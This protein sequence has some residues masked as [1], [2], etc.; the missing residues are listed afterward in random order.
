[1]WEG[2]WRLCFVG[3]ESD[4]ELACYCFDVLRRQ[5]QRDIRRYQKLHCRRCKRGTR[6]QRTHNYAHGWIRSA[7]RLL[8]IF[9]QNP[10]RLALAKQSTHEK[11]VEPISRRNLPAAVADRS[12][13]VLHGMNDGSNAQLNRGI[14]ASQRPA[15]AAEGERC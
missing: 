13:A 1:M 6:I 15:L 9:D 7:R 3:V 8:D 12:G 5:L 4:A 14:G 2:R 10:K 11:G